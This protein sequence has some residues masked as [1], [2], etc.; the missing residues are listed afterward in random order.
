M[1]PLSLSLLVIAVCCLVAT[2]HA[3]LFNHEQSFNASAVNGQ[4]G[5]DREGRLLLPAASALLTPDAEG[6]KPVSDLQH[7]FSG[8][9]L[10]ASNRKGSLAIYSVTDGRI[11]LFQADKNKVYQRLDIASQLVNAVSLAI[12]EEGYLYLADAKKRRVVVID[13]DG[14]Y[15]GWVSND[16]AKLDGIVAIAVN[17]AKELHILDKAAQVHVFHPSGKKLRSH[18]QLTKAAGVSLTAPNA[19]VALPDGGFAVADSKT[20]SIVFFDAYG[21]KTGVLGSKGSGNPGTFQRLDAIALS[22]EDIPALAVYDGISQ[23]AQVFRADRGIGVVEAENNRPRIHPADAPPRPVRCL[24][25]TADGAQFF[26]PADEPSALVA[27]EANGR[28]RFTLASVFKDAVAITTDASGFVYIADAKAK[29]IEVYSTEGAKIRHFGDEGKYRLKQP[30]GVAVQKNGMVIV[31]DGGTGALS[32]WASAGVFERELVA[33]AKAGWKKPTRIAVDSKDQIYVLDAGTQ[34]V[35]RTGSNGHPV[36]LQRIALRSEKPGKQGVA[37]DFAVDRFDQIHLFNGSTG[38]WEVFAWDAIEPELLFRYGRSADWLPGGVAVERIAMNHE[39]FRLYLSSESKRIS[40]ASDFVVKP[41]TPSDEFN[42]AINDG[43]LVVSFNT[44][45]AGFITGYGLLTEGKRGDTLA[46]TTNGN[47][48]TLPRIGLAGEV[49]P[50]YKLVSMSRNALSDPN[51]GFTDHFSYAEALLEGGRFD[52]ALPAYQSAVDRMGR[53]KIFRNYMALRLAAQGEALALRGDVSRAMPYLRLAHRTAPDEPQVISAYR[54][55]YSSYFRE[56]L[57]REDVNSILVESRRLIG[58]TVLKPIV[59]ESLDSLSTEL[60]RERGE[61]SL[62]RAVLLRR[63]MVEWAPEHANYR[64]ALGSSLRNLYEWK[65]RAGASL[66][67]LESLL[68]EAERFITQGI[69]ELRNQRQPVLQPELMLVDLLL[70]QARY[71]EAEALVRSLLTEHSGSGSTA[72]T[73]LKLKLCEAYKGKGLFSP[74]ADEYRRLAESYPSERKYRELL[75]RA[76]ADAGDY[77]EARQVFEKLLIERRGDAGYTAEIGRIELLREN[78]IEAAYQLDRALKLDAGNTTLHGLLAEALDR[79]S[80]S[81]DALVQYAAAIRHED[82]QLELYRKRLANIRKLNESRTRLTQHLEAVARLQTVMGKS[83]L[84][85]QPLQ[86]LV[87]LHPNTARYHYDYGNACM[88]TGRVYDAEKAFYTATRLEAGNRTYAAAHEQ[89][90]KE[91]TRL[92]SKLDPLTF[93]EVKMN[94]VFPSLYRNYADPSRLPIGEVVIA[95]NTDGIIDLEALTVRIPDL[96]VETRVPVANLV[97][98]ANTVIKLNAVLPEAVLANRQ[99]KTLPVTISGTYTQGG[100]KLTLTRTENI[101]LHPGNAIHWGD[102]R[103]LASF[104]STGVDE[105]IAFNTSIQNTFQNSD[106]GNINGAIV[107]TLQ[108]YTALS[109]L[110][111][112]YQPDPQF[113]YAVLSAGNGSLDYVQ[114]PIETLVKRRGDCDDFVVV[115]AGLLENAGIQTAYI[116][117][118]GHV[119]LAVNTLLAPHE[120]AAAGLSP[121]DVIIDGNEVWIPIETTLAGEVGFMTAWEQ[122]LKRYNSELQRGVYPELV[123]MSDAR[124]AYAPANFVPDG[125]E[126]PAQFAPSASGAYE[127]EL[128]QLRTRLRREVTLSI[129]GRYQREPGNVFVKNK[130]AVLLARE[131]NLA[132]AEGVLLEALDLSPN[133]A[134]VLNNLGNVARLQGKPE[135]AIDYYQ[136]AFAIDNNDAEICVNLHTTFSNLGDRLRAEEWL[137]KAC[138]I[139]PTLKTRYGKLSH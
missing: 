47:S 34:S 134:V 137:E 135:Q 87:S 12:D 39:L 14:R 118:P 44:L 29:R 10:V 93:A 117:V 125:C 77:E 76:L 127:R 42:F 109:A 21:R 50:R 100:R 84:A 19:L 43:Q 115:F 79:S 13:A 17:A 62:T 40:S 73:A 95:N 110:P 136:K 54:V 105:L 31:C 102:K 4:P 38:Q 96:N 9:T 2:A 64:I 63:K 15:T 116:D 97:G 121:R 52:E 1:R 122:G 18:L 26:I 138:E 67:E 28:V 16:E 7:G 11:A 48:F 92:A 131:G 98:Y 89:S 113:N 46:F 133:N 22:H 41:P 70:L 23:R 35:F 61:R 72:V 128:D 65:N 99:S 104:V 120:L 69:E 68:G 66:A 3:Q 5:F 86:R 71:G 107:Q 82:Q 32:A 123:R 119:F 132:R 24:A 30:S 74:A 45:E 58:S 139:E 106:A 55:G 83:E 114:Y 78:Y 112:S 91:R 101:T 80:N 103:R 94:E 88:A 124:S 129:E 49:A 126:V 51:A 90:L 6:T 75:G 36:A 85:I 27:L 25:T 111:L 33:A 60:D 108:T 20:C 57:G 37:V 53:S 130:Y 56:L 81:G 59:L 8:K